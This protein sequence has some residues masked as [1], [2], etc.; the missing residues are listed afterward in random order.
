MVFRGL[1]GM[2]D[3]SSDI[4]AI[5]LAGGTSSRMGR[6]N[7]ALLE[8]DGKKIIQREVE[9]LE[10]LFEEIIV[11]TNTFDHYDFLGKPMFSDVR[12]GYGSLGG[13]YTGL[14]NCSNE[15]GFVLP[16]DMPFLNDRVI[17]YVCQRSF[18][19]DVTVPKIGVHY[20]PL[21]AVYSRRCVPH[22][23]ALMSRGKLRIFD[24]FNDVDVLEI[25]EEELRII[26]PKLNFTLNVNSPTDFTS[27]INIAKTV[28]S[29]S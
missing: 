7:K 29:V 25:Q 10:G 23:E 12:P 24:F 13:L 22:M 4:T 11:I 21:H 17:N 26:D 15:Y 19:H 28:L 18:G 14:V 3:Y 6:Q 2:R 20:E 1:N 8:I 9:I 16:C 27:A 5:L